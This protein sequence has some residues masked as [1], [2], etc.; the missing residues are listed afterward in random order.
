MKL[1]DR[2]NWKE[3]QPQ[4]QGRENCPLCNESEEFTIW[5]GKYWRICHNKYPILALENH[6]MA[7]PLR[8]VILSGNLTKQEYGEMKEVELFMEKFYL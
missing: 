1:H 3:H 7:V 6:L 8:H 5:I 4:H 2:K